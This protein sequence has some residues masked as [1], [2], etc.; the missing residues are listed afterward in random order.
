M[1]TNVQILWFLLTILFFSTDGYNQENYPS[2]ADAQCETSF[3][4]RSKTSN[5]LYEQMANP[6]VM[7]TNSQMYPDFPTYTCQGADD[8]IIMPGQTWL[9]DEVVVM[10]FLQPLSGGP[11][12]QA[13]LF[14]FENIPSANSP[15]A[16]LF[17]KLLMPVEFNPDGFLS[18]FLPEPVILSS[19]HY[20]ISVQP[21][22]P[23][24]PS[25]QW[26]WRRQSAPTI[27]EEFRWQNPG[28]GFGLPNT[29][30]WQKASL[31]NFGNTSTDYNLS[32]AIHGTLVDQPVEPEFDMIIG[33]Y[34]NPE[35]WNNWIGGD[36]GL[37]KVTLIPSNVGLTAQRNIEHVI[38]TF[39]IDDL[40]YVD[41]Y[42]DAD[43]S[44][45][46]LNSTG[47]DYGTG[48]GWSGYLPHEML[49]QF[50]F[51]LFIK[52]MVVLKDGSGYEVKKSIMYDPTPP[53]SVTFN[54]YD[55]LA[56]EHETI[57]INI[58]PGMA[59]DLMEAQI[60]V[61]NKQE[62]FEKGVGDYG[63][64]DDDGC[65][66]A[67]AAAC[68]KWFADSLNDNQIMGGLTLDQLYDQ[69]YEVFKTSQRVLE[70]GTNMFGAH[71]EDVVSGLNSWI[72]DH[73]DRYRVNLQNPFNWQEMRAELEKKQEVLTTFYYNTPTGQAGHQVTFNSIKNRPEENGTIRVDFMDPW[74]DGGIQHGYLN[75]E[76]GQIT[77]YT[78][79]LFDDG[80][81]PGNII[82]CPEEEDIN[83]P[84]YEYVVAG[85][86]FDPITVNLG[87]PGLKW[88]RIRAIDASGH[89]WQREFIVERLP[90]RPLI[91]KI[92]DIQMS[93]SEQIRVTGSHF[94][95][96]SAQSAILFNGIGFQEE[97]TFWSDTLVIFTCPDLSPADYMLSINCTGDVVSD[98][99][100]VEIL[101]AGPVD[102]IT[103]YPLERVT[104][105]L[106]DIQVV[107]PIAR[108]LVDSVM[109]F[110]TP[111]G[112]T[113]RIHIGTDTDGSVT[114]A[115][116]YS[117][118]GSGNGWHVQWQV[119]SFFDIFV[120]LE[121][122]AYGKNGKIYTGATSIFFDPPPYLLK[123]NEDVSKL[124]GGS[125]IPDDF[126]KI[127]FSADEEGL[128]LLEL[129]AR[130]LG[131][132]DFV[133]Q[134][135]HV[136]QD[137]ITAT[138]AN[139]NDISNDICGPTSAA[140]CLD[141]LNKRAGGNGYTSISDS[142]R[143]IARRAGTT[144]GQGTFDDSLTNAI[145]DM[146]NRDPKLKDG[147][148]TRYTERPYNQIG[149][150]LRDGADV[151]IL[152]NQKLADGTTVGHYVAVSS[153]HSTIQY[154]PGPPNSG[155]LCVAVQL[156]YIDFMD[157][158]TGETVYK[159][160]NW[161]KNPPT[162]M[163]YN[164]GEQQTDGEASIESTIVVTAPSG[165]RNPEELYLWS[166]VVTPNGS[167]NYQISV[168]TTELPEGV[169]AFEVTR[170]SSNYLPMMESTI[171]VNGQYEPF[172]Y[173]D[174]D[175][176]V[177]YAP[178]AV[179][180]TD[181]SLPADSV[182]T[183][184]WDFGDG[185]QSDEQHPV[186]VYLQPGYYSVSLQV[187]DGNT[188]DAYQI[189][190]LIHVLPPVEFTIN[191]PAGWSG[192]SSHIIP[193]NQDLETML[194]P[195]DGN[196]IILYNNDGLFW[197]GEDINTLGN[198]NPDAGYVV[199]MTSDAVL[200]I[201]GQPNPQKTAL[202]PSGLNI[203]HIPIDCAISTNEIMDQ[204]GENL[205]YIQGIATSQ[206]FLPQYGVDYLQQL[207]PGKAYFIKTTSD[208]MIQFPECV[209]PAD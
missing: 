203:L 94:K 161:T 138:D 14:L 96:Q 90:V 57:L 142:I 1:K 204:L 107:V 63:Q 187:S 55:W 143:R 141:W 121:A 182:T 8:F 171:I 146:M 27:F 68:L 66:A 19:G 105:N 2:V 198:W 42:F 175:A 18:L 118:I 115:G 33:K 170:Y 84:G 192:I 177:G 30:T 112:G 149:R 56:V 158:A 189:E 36:Q 134:L 103:P 7:G 104:N 194:Q 129:G 155:I 39:S 48:D 79:E 152:L 165:S 78:G 148:V 83:L 17:E 202:L 186:H 179:Q 97:V 99:Y 156:D 162:I 167:G 41:F 124:I 34:L 21:V 22:M 109:F 130:P 77:G 100:P 87:E 91:A 181:L 120:N 73:G 140:V 81:I 123:I 119:D 151:I 44:N 69:L 13:N 92:E 49:P 4:S 65:A 62:E 126:I 199:K 173:F 163:D 127:D 52:A 184:L 144:Q 45:I 67:S 25:G 40:N 191:L 88:V 38:F 80:T 50:D 53:S 136:D 133:R 74:G 183:W 85:P 28:G 206:V 64:F 139:N 61:E 111:Q 70:D 157:P 89:A 72:A 51:E 153:H 95:E 58:F 209:F 23:F 117:P 164:I 93:F 24:N 131:G 46:V 71:Y 60:S 106:V 169:F 145:R 54:I 201:S 9:I 82:I 200:T 31:I 47:P 185:N 188:F 37:T 154:Q 172:A 190:N 6:T 174:V 110:A 102:F 208:A 5:S 150:N 98:P 59:S 176:T 101:P 3:I 128:D 16:L 196:L 76:T 207:V 160:V 125:I 205:I 147:T 135:R 20:W 10:G 12:V 114:S 197:P 168:P 116:T 35:P 180:F 11:L 137:T 159:Q 132:F 86:D 43:G 108:H 195:V 32:F 26:F 29:F 75:P 15:G 122:E 178:L 113:D 166:Q 193:S